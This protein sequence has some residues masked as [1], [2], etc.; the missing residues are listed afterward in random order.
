MNDELTVNLNDFYYQLGLSDTETGKI[1]GWDVA[2]GP[3]RPRY[4]STLSEND[5]PCLVI[6]FEKPAGYLWQ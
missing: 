2:N 3:I 1:L 6:G 5:E 4:T